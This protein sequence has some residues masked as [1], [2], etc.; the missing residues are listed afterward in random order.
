[1]FEKARFFQDTFLVSNTSIE[2]ILKMPFLSFSKVK[3][4]FAEREL[5]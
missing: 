3:V 2:V 1:M 4:D 5:T